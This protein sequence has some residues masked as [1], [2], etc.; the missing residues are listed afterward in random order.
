[1]L[2]YFPRDWTKMMS[3]T[4]QDLGPKH[5]YNNLIHRYRRSQPSN[6]LLNSQCD[7]LSEWVLDLPYD[8]YDPHA[9]CTLR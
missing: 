1:M 5:H 9:S 6:Y 8:P 7:I 3:S 4:Y 2:A